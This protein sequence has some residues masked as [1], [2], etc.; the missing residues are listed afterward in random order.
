MECNFRVGDVI[1]IRGD[2]ICPDYGNTW[3]GLR[4][5]PG[6]AWRSGRAIPLDQIAKGVIRHIEWSENYGKHYALV[7]LMDHDVIYQ[8]GLYDHCLLLRRG[9]PLDTAKVRTTRSGQPAVNIRRSGDP[10]RPI[11]AD[12]MGMALSYQDSGLFYGYIE[13]PIDLVEAPT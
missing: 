13:L 11:M 3:E 2:S 12:V 6:H 7:A 4:N 9:K 8:I 5:F 1:E 10:K